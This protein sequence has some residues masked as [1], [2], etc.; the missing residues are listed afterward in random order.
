MTIKERKEK[1]V[2]GEMYTVYTINLTPTS[3]YEGK[4]K[5]KKIFKK[6]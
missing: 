2:A 4:K 6:I 1:V 3:I 5:K